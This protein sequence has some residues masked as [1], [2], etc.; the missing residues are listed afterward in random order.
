[1][2]YL[3]NLSVPEFLEIRDAANIIMQK[4]KDKQNA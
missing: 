1:M 3:D 4:I 2:E